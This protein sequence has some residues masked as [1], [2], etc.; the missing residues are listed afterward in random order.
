MSQRNTG[1]KHYL[2]TWQGGG[3]KET[4]FF[5]GVKYKK[6]AQGKGGAT[7]D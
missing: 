6:G 7:K 1:S 3:R 4:K 5:N 2:H